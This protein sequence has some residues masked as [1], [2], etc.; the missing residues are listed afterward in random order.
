MAKRGEF[1]FDQHCARCHGTYEKAWSLPEANRL[2]KYD[3]VKTVRTWYHKK[4]PVI[5]VGTDPG[6]WEGMQYFA[7]E[8][9]RLKISQSLQTVV[10]PQRGYVPPPLDGIWARWPYF[11]NNSAPS[12]CAVLTASE[13]RPV[14]YVAGPAIRPETDYDP[15]CNGYPSPGTAPVEWLSLIHI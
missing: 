2:T 8:L 14:V 12:L 15:D 4:T 6:R 3:L 1:Q 9:N 5:N 7:T 13:L 10:V 11:H